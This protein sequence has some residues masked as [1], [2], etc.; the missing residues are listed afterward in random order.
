M[1]NSGTHEAAPWACD[2]LLKLLTPGT[3]LI[4]AVPQLREAALEA[5]ISCGGP[6]S[7]FHQLSAWPTVRDSLLMQT[8]LSPRAAGWI[9]E[10]TTIG[11]EPDPEPEL[12]PE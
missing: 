8:G 12:E 6:S 9:L 1:P 11:L 10:E 4:A 3:P 2:P 7:V 5:F